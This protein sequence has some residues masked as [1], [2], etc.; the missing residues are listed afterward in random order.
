MRLTHQIDG[1]PRYLPADLTSFLSDSAELAA[2]VAE[3]SD[4]VIVGHIA[5]HAGVGDAAALVAAGSR[6]GTPTAGSCRPF[7]GPPR[8]Q[9]S[10]SCAK[11]A[12]CSN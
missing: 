3:S 5:L 7:D 10:W 9:A 12:R 6:L 2:W 4:N 11:I 1:Y 8:G